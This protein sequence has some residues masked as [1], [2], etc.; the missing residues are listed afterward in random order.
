MPEKLELLIRLATEH[1]IM[2]Y[3][4]MLRN[5]GWGIMWSDEARIKTPPIDAVCHGGPILGHIR[6]YSENETKRHKE[7]LVVYRYY[8]TFDEMLDGELER[9]RAL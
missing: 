5:A 9:I 4:I 7:S 2:L 6:A 8:R 3:D 1:G